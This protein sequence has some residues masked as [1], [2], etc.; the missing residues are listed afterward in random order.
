MTSFHT[1]NQHLRP[2]SK[3]LSLLV[4]L[5]L[6]ASS[7]LAFNK[8]GLV[9]ASNTMT[10]NPSADAYVYQLQASTNYG[11]NKSIRVDTSPVMN[12]YLRFDISGIAGDAVNKV[13]LRI[14]ANSHS[15]AGFSVHTVGEDNWQEKQITFQ[16]APS[17]GEEVGRSHEFPAG[18]WV[19]V[20]VTSLLNSDGP[21]SIALQGIDTTQINLASRNDSNHKP[22]LVIETVSV[23]TSTDTAEPTNPPPAPTEELTNPP[24]TPTTEPTS[25]TATS[26]VVPTNPPSTATSE[27]TETNTPQPTELPA[28]GY[29]PT[30]PIRA[31][32][33][34]P[35]FPEAWSQQ[36]YALFTNY[37]PNLGLY[38]SG[39]VSVIQEQIAAMTYGNIEAGILS[40][41]GQGSK[42]DQRVS[43]ILGATPGSSNPNFRWSIYYENESQG[44]PSVSQIENDLAYI[45]SKYGSDAS[46]L[47]VNGRFVVFVYADASDAC[48]M[49]DRWTQANAALGNSAYLVL[50]VFAGYRNCA[51]QPDSWHQ[52]APAVATDEQ[53]GYSYAV[54]PGFYKTGENAPRLERNLNAWNSDVQAMV[55]SNE[56]WQLVTTFNEWGEGTSVEQAL[57]WSS[58]SGFGQYLDALHDNGSKA[59]PQPTQQPPTPTS[60]PTSPPATSTPQPTQQQTP[61]A[62]PTQLP[63]GGNDP[64]LY[65]TSDLDS[66][67]SVDRGTLV[68]NQIKKL[69]AQHPG[70]QMLVASAG[71]N[72]QENNPTL[73]NYQDYFGTT[74]GQFVTQ[75]IFMQVRGNHDIQSAGSY[76]DPNGHIHS[77]GA[78]YWDYF[79][80]NSHGFNIDGQLLTD[81]SYDLGTWHIIGLDQLNGSVNTATL[82][83]LQS[84]L[85]ANSDSTCQLV[86]W[87]VPTYSSGAAHGDA[88]GLVP[89]N[90][91]EYD[92]GV[93]IQINGHDHDYQRFY[94][95]NPSGV[96]DDARGITTFVAGIGGQDGRSGSQT[97]R[98]QAA[99]A[100]YLD[101]FLGDHAIGVI[102]FTLHPTS[103]DY[104][105]YDA[106]TG[107]VLDQGTVYCH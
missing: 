15:H 25:L 58:P 92:A 28:G 69:M 74:Y 106:N 42:T 55:S 5:I 82:N 88:T 63:S 59:V 107:S 31:A 4:V 99:S 20:D 72:E 78:A 104:T 13:T 40:W 46:F 27:P 3:Y 50:K 68:V 93:D 36:G 51:S 54:S 85:A 6:V 33:F 79:G 83:F 67:S 24:S 18:T 64:I 16:N 95:I 44:N 96:R 56:P 32:F 17:I 101:S 53:R 87:H 30:F 71:D 60:E 90:Q 22:E 100:V 45:Q 86:Y 70:T 41:W 91:A 84:D 65:M 66:G 77:S 11:D 37:T 19:D 10:F 49:A 73:S 23:N 26:T 61:A 47:R 7:F 80:A 9:K 1:I 38:D 12:S 94:P 48:G 29:Q 89:L 34:Y 35:W 57:E 2:K 97:S 39:S 98:A 75:G 21:V 43:T 105:L 103:A 52:Y 62:S 81:Y 102:E 76:T 14:Y 8:P